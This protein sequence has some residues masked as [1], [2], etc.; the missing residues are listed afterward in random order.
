MYTNE[1]GIKVYEL[2]DVVQVGKGKARWTVDFVGVGGTAVHLK[3]ESGREMVSVIE[4]LTLIE[5][6]RTTTEIVGEVAEETPL[7]SSYGR[8][9]LFALQK[10]PTVFQGVGTKESRARRRAKNKVTRASR[11]ANRR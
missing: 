6:V 1:Q 7:T 4:R 2:G 9:I 3:S 5:N 11:K 10:L 8:A